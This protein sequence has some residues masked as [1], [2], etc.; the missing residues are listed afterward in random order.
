MCKLLLILI[1][2]SFIKSDAQTPMYR[3]LRKQAT[4]PSFVLDTYTGALGAYSLRQ[5]R[6]GQTNCI[7]VR[8]SSDNTE[9]DI[10]F[11]S[12]VI[13]QAS[14]LSFVGAGHGS[15]VTWYDQSGNGNDAATSANF[16][17]IVES[18]VLLEVNG[19][20][21]VDFGTNAQPRWVS[22][23]TGFLNGATSLSYFQVAEITDFASSNA[24]VFGPS[25]T[26]A[27][28]LEILQVSVISR[29]TFLRF[30]GTARNDNSGAAYQLWDDATQSLTSIFG[31]STDVTV[32]KNSAAVT[33]TSAAAMPTLNFNG[34]YS[35]GQYNSAA[36][37][38]YGKIQELIIYSSD[39][40]SNRTG[41]ETNIN[42]FYS[43]Y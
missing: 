17:M 24:G 10:G 29:R 42:S 12:G 25:N 3:L 21:T 35:I 23:P 20:P 9:Q 7:R 31:N 30:N 13:D 27:V 26:N 38:M 37:Y 41:I 19:K 2:F 4:P 36:N 32:Y 15:V 14:L 5:L 40:T 34:V 8:R 16:P 6:T 11:S 22:L 33:L 1:L 28:G 39:E 43:V 18:G